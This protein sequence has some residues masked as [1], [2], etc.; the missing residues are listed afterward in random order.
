MQTIPLITVNKIIDITSGVAPFQYQW[1]TTDPCVTFSAAS[2]TATDD[3][4]RLPA[5]VLLGGDDG[6]AN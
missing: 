6:A 2:G 1:T 4:V 3:Q 5:F